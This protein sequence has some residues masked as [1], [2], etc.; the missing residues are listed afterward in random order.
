MLDLPRQP[1]C[2]HST[3]TTLPALVGHLSPGNDARELVGKLGAE[4]A[5]GGSQRSSMHC[6]QMGAQGEKAN[7]SRSK[8]LA[9]D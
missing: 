3:E 9:E 1:K 4:W 5:F 8:G 7:L 2:S 6:A